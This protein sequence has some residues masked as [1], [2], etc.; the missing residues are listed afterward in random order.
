V[1]AARWSD[2]HRL[3]AYHRDAASGSLFLGVDLADGTM[4]ELGEAAPG[5]DAFLDRASVTLSGM[6]AYSAWDGA[7]AAAPG[8]STGIVLFEC[9]V[10][11]R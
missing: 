11:R 5:F 1:A 8:D 7:L 3:R 4:L 9:A 6:L 10:R 2:I